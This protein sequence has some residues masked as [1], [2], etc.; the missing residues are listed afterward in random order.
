MAVV[1]GIAAIA[2]VLLGAMLYSTFPLIGETYPALKNL[3]TVLPG[4]AGIS[5]AANPDGAIAQT[6]DKVQALWAKRGATGPD[7]D[8]NRAVALLSPAPPEVVPELVLAGGPTPSADEI[9]VMD[10]ETGLSWGRCHADPR[11]A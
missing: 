3:M 4:L 11:D 5:L 10:A 9:A 7:P 1:G 6:V 8:R 2:G